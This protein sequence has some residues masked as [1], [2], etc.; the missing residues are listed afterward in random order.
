M[1]DC[2]LW[3]GTLDDARV[4]DGEGHDWLTPAEQSRLAGL[5]AP[6][7]RRQFLA[8]HWRLR[9]LAAEFA[10]G[11]A[12]DWRLAAAPG[13]QPWLEG[14]GGARL[15]ASI[16][17]SGEWLAVAVADRAIGV[18]VEVPR[19]ERDYDALARHVFAPA[20]V[21]RHEALAGAE[22]LAAFNT[23][24]AL[25]E[26]FG[27]RAGQGLQPHAARGTSS[28][29]A[30]AAEAEAFTWPLPGDGALAVAAWP[31]MVP[32]LHAA[33]TVG[34]ARGWRYRPAG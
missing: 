32:G 14:P 30:P 5:S 33:A 12:G 3:L 7:R 21:A 19:R 17:H 26:A 18:D 16:S 11:Q 1:A 27:K 4:A 25:K 23:T 28:E 24:W 29:P 8:G 15:C 2:R 20:E 13:G 22:R 34:A 9:A 31:G 6:L 10:G